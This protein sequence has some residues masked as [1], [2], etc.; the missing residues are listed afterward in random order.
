VVTYLKTDVTLPDLSTY[1]LLWGAK[2]TKETV[3]NHKTVAI[4]YVKIDKMNLLK[5][6]I[7]VQVSPLITLD[8]FKNT[9]LQ[10]SSFDAGDE[11]SIQQ[12]RGSLD[13]RFLSYTCPSQEGY[14]LFNLFD[15]VSVKPSIPLKFAVLS[16]LN[17]FFNLLF[18][19]FLC[20]VKRSLS[21]LPIFLEPHSDLSS[22]MFFLGVV[23]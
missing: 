4:H 11:K 6:S 23:A 3:V 2:K 20:L 9:L 16:L 1:L 5:W 10:G 7:L 15:K 14:S 8:S 18:N 21:Y 22:D 19:L 12:G 13:P 17:F